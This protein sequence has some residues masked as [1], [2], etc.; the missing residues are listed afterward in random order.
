MPMAPAMSDNQM[1]HYKIS[2]ACNRQEAESINARLEIDNQWTRS[3]DPPTIVTRELVDFDDSQWMIDIYLNERPSSSLYADIETLLGR[4]LPKDQAAETFVDEDW[5]TMSQEGLESITI[6][7]FHV[8]N[9]KQQPIK[10]KINIRMSAGQAFGTGHH[11]TTAGCLEVLHHYHS[12]NAH[13]KNIADIGTGTGL[14]AFAAHKLWPKSAIIASDLDPV[15]CQFAIDAAHDNGIKIGQGNSQIEIVEASGTDHDRIQQ[16]APYDLV[17]A[18][19]LAGPLI[20]LAPAF[21]EILDL[22]GILILAGLLDKQLDSIKHA[23]A[24]LS[25]VKQSNLGEWPIL[26][27]KKIDEHQNCENI[28][29]RTSQKDGDYGEW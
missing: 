15:A 10:D 5:V 12:Q 25:L 22:N 20:E 29:R 17:I 2:I 13:Y 21:E 4:E 9:D 28:K 14:L 24:N 11:N 26:V 19:I 23:Y 8:H 1:E 16:R 3:L 27:F 18:N 6:A 7:A